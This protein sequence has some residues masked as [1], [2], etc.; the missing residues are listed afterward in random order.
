[1]GKLDY[2]DESTFN[3]GHIE[4]HIEPA[5][6]FTKRFGAKVKKVGGRYSEVRGDKSKRFVTIP[7]TA[8]TTALV[9]DIVSE[10][11]CDTVVLRPWV[12][13]AD[14]RYPRRDLKAGKELTRLSLF[15]NYMK[16]TQERSRG[17]LKEKRAYEKEKAERECEERPVKLMAERARLKERL[18]EIEAELEQLKVKAV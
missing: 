14:V 9:Q 4:L 16:W 18:A 6:D 7:V 13:K 17:A 12:A 2:V 11:R 1:M 8:F 3:Q 10:F 5:P 15:K